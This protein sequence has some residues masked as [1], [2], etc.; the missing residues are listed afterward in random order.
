MRCEPVRGFICLMVLVLLTFNSSIVFCVPKRAIKPLTTY[1]DSFVGVDGG[2]NTVPGA[3]T[4][5]GFA[6]PSPDTLQHDTSG[7]DSKQPIIGFSQTHVSGTGGA[8]KYG[9]FRIT[10]EVGELKTTE[11]A[12]AKKD[13]TASPGY[14]AVTLTRPD[15]RVELTASRVVAVHRY[16]FPKST[17]SQLLL[18]VSSIVIAGGEQRQHI[19]D[20]SA[21]I[22]APDRIEGTGQFKGGWN[23][24]PYTLHF[25][26]EFSRAPMGY[27]VWSG[28]ALQPHKSS[29]HGK[30]QTGVYLTFDTTREAAIEVRIGLSFVST[31]QARANLEREVGT[32]TFTEVRRNAES[33][34]EEAL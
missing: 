9:N 13:E 26:A 24:A 17:A 16:T 18:D 21:T 28:D 10:P 29:I 23:P 33:A 6:N 20:C 11:L 25:S 12:S 27:G 2:G 15:V 8:S 3:T 30:D 1:C 4:P 7:Y 32:H 5:F 14:Y 31:E 19:V 22:V 34:W